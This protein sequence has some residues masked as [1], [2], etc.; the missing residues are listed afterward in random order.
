MLNLS[1]GIHPNAEGYAVVA[2]NVFEFL[3]SKR[4][5]VK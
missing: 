5:V 2:E 3:K 1:D 4:L